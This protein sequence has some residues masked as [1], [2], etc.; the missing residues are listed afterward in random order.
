MNEI[1]KDIDGYNYQI[2]SLGNIRSKGKYVPYIG[3]NGKPCK[4][5]AKPTVLK[6]SVGTSGYPTTHIYD[7]TPTRKTIMIHRLVAEYFL[8]PVEG[9]EFVN[10]I[11]G[12]KTNN[13]V[14]NLEWVTKSENTVHAIETG[15][16]NHRGEKSNFNKLSEKEVIELI[17]ARRYL[18]GK[19][20]AR[21][22]SEKYGICEKYAATFGN[23]KNKWDHLKDKIENTDL[24]VLAQQLLKRWGVAT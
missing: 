23:L 1:W 13:V 19:V 8:E 2:S 16:L 5:W 14:T 6:W 17:A 3:R 7:D 18:K 10:H 12:D 9:K 20:T 22:L 24:E 15:L 11:D 21:Q 4:R